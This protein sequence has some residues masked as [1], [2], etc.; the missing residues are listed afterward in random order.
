MY[1]RVVCEQINPYV[2]YQNKTPAWPFG[3]FS[4]LSGFSYSEAAIEQ[5][6]LS[7]CSQTCLH[8][9]TRSSSVSHYLMANLYQIS[10]LIPRM[11]EDQ[12]DGL[13][14]MDM[15]TQKH[16]WRGGTPVKLPAPLPGFLLRL[17]KITQRRENNSQ[18]TELQLHKL[19]RH[20]IKYIFQTTKANTEL[21]Q[22]LWELKKQKTSRMISWQSV[23]ITM[24]S[25][26][27]IKDT[28]QPLKTHS[29]LCAAPHWL[30]FMLWF[31]FWQS[32]FW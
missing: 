22:F 3:S 11:P 24:E 12:H 18:Q 31:P 8:P 26:W 20:A 19:N 10:T 30:L 9:Q 13:F 4:E 17:Q 6:F 21:S 27:T 2:K 23:V 5:I 32:C 1:S 25:W 29:Q 14:K 15:M 16:T 28:I 7:A